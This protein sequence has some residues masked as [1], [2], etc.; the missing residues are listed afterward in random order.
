[1]VENVERFDSEFQCP[2][3]SEYEI[4][5]ERQIELRHAEA[6]EHVSSEISLDAVGAGREC[7]AV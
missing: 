2:F 5:T 1:M 6:G 4:V 3:L 7:R